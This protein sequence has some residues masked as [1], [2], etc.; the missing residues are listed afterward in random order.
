MGVHQAAERARDQHQRYAHPGS[1]M[2]SCA[3]CDKHFTPQDY[4]SPEAAEKA[5]DEHQALHKFGCPMCPRLFAVSDYPSLSVAKHARDQHMQFAHPASGSERSESSDDDDE[6]YLCAHCDRSF[7]ARDYSST[8]AAMRAHKQHQDTHS[9]TEGEAGADSDGDEQHEC[10][11]CDRLFFESDY[12]SSNA[13]RRARDQHQATGKCTGSSQ[14]STPR[15]SPKFGASKPRKSPRFVS[16]SAATPSARLAQ[17][18]QE[19][20]GWMAKPEAF[21]YAASTSPVPPGSVNEWENM[22]SS[23]IQP[24]LVPVRPTY[25]ASYNPHVQ[26]TLPAPAR[27][28]PPYNPHVQ[29]TLPAPARSS[30]VYGYSNPMVQTVLPRRW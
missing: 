6:G 4:G 29:V 23:T 7:Y 26:V 14:S 28:S 1:R 25:V 16:A 22:L 20:M 10:Q 18:A 5:R 3:L 12:A 24:G 2:C 17:A 13:A 30:P 27:S 11:Y 21:G 15:V 9:D 19:S 8:A